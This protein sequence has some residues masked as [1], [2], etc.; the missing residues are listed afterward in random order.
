M[1]NI[2]RS[3]DKLEFNK[4]IIMIGQNFAWKPSRNIIDIWEKKIMK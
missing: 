1:D 2:E 4:G 3:E